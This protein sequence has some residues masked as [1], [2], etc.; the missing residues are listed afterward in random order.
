[1]L[2]RL[3]DLPKV[4]KLVGGADRIQIKAS[5]QTLTSVFLICM[6]YKSP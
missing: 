2:R 3:S 6:L 1:M 5:S 4:I